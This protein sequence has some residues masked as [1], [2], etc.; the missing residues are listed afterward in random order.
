MEKK[1]IIYI[2]IDDDLGKIGISTPIIGEN[3]VKE[4][5]NIAS[6]KIPTD[7]DFNT[8]VVA[9]NIYKKM[10]NQ[11]ENVEIVLLTGDTNGGLEAQMKF[12]MKLDKVLNELKPDSV[13]VVFDSPEDSK[14]IPII[15][16]RVKVIGIERV[17]VEQYRSVEETYVLLGRYLRK[18]LS[19]PRYSRIFLGVPGLILLI[20]SILS[21]LNLS[22]YAGPIILL[23]IGIVMLARGL[24]I[25]EM[26]ENWWESSSIMVVATILS[27]S[28]LI[29]GSVN[30]YLSYQQLRD[31]SISNI[32]TLALIFLPYGVFSIT[33]LFISKAIID[34]SRHDIRAW[35]HVLQAIAMVLVY[36]VASSFLES[37][38]QNIITIQPFI[39]LIAS[40]AIL[41]SVYII[42]SL[43][44]KY[45]L[46]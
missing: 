12:S 23:I 27:L 1:L 28:S 11:G 9:Y 36:F 17:L 34:I 40:T 26:I 46:K 7:S 10:K 44:E 41:V 30:L 35:H 43:L 29:V 38:R 20:S 6:E 2:D 5:I 18:A 25:D 16:S 24:R 39:G 8:L 32:A 45:K 19:D 42:I 3:N 15:Q 21:I 37:I 33:V 31:L 22:S 4:V 14:A 13:I